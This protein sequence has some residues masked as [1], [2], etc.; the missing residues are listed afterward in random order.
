MTDLLDFIVKYW[1]G[2]L[3]GAIGIFITARFKKWKQNIHDYLAMKDEKNGKKLQDNIIM[4]IKPMLEEIS[5]QSELKDAELKAEVEV[6]KTSME[7]ITTSINAVSSGVLNMQGNIFKS[8]CKELLQPGIVIEQAQYEKCMS[9][10]NVYNSLGGNHD[11][12]HLFNLVT[13]KYTH[14]LKEN[15]IGK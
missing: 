8:E 7:K 6:L 14:Q 2:F 4:G 10:H 12:D 13:A 3:F 9:D 5:K 1:L 15:G 11:G